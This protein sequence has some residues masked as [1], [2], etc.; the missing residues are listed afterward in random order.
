MAL[1]GSTVASSTRRRATRDWGHRAR[2]RP[3]VWTI[4]DEMRSVPMSEC[5][6]S[7]RCS[8][9]T[10]MARRTPADA[11]GSQAHLGRCPACRRASLPGRCA[12]DVLH[13]R[14]TGSSPSASRNCA[15]AARPASARPRLRGALARRLA[16][17]PSH[18]RGCRCRSPRPSLLA[19]ARGVLRAERQRRGA[20]DAARARSRQVLPVRP[21]PRRGR[22]G[23]RRH[24]AGRSLRL[25]D[26]RAAQRAGRAA[27]APRRA[28]LHVDAGRVGAHHVQVARAAAV[29]LRAQ[30]RAESD[31]H[32]ERLVVA[33][34]ARRR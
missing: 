27:R 2:V 14:R 16:A 32:V 8:P 26:H 25:A 9:P 33:P 18:A 28:A 4:S 30:Q 31:V 13:A 7:S 15:S 5:A 24:G 3:G 11:G 12:R 22:S 1:R 29:G 10:S 23:R 19:V 6:S 34:R 21:G 20:G 17:S